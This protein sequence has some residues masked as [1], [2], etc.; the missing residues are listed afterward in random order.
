MLRETEGAP[1]GVSVSDSQRLKPNW[2]RKDTMEMINIHDVVLVL[3]LIAIAISPR[4][5]VTYLAVRK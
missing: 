1:Q 5:I 4:A 2:R 3:V